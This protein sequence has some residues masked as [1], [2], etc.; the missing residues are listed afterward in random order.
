LRNK[1]TTTTAGTLLKKTAIDVLAR[2]L[3]Y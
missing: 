2:L 1:T 3:G